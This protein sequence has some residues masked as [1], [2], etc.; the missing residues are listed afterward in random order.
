MD[1]I[2]L[3]VSGC[4]S[5]GNREIEGVSLHIWHAW[6]GKVG[7]TCRFMIDMD[8][9]VTEDYD[10]DMETLIIEAKLSPVVYFIF[11][12]H[13]THMLVLPF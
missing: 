6:V 11:T 8:S 4:G 12:N 13:W 1:V 10:A 9:P 2:G 5:R 3:G 7:N